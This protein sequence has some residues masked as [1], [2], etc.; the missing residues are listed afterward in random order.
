MKSFL[1]LLVSLLLWIPM[2]SQI[3]G[4]P[5]DTTGRAWNIRFIVDAGLVPL[6]MRARELYN[7]EQLGPGV[8]RWAEWDSTRN[9]IPGSKL[10]HQMISF[11]LG[12]LVNVFKELYVGVNY[13]AY[14]AQ[15]APPSQPAF[16]RTSI[17]FIS[18]SGSVNYSFAFPK[19]PRLRLEPTLSY[20]NYQSDPYAEGGYEGI[21]KEQSFEGRVALAYQYRKKRRHQVRL[22]ASF[23]RMQYSEKTQSL[24]YPDRTRRIFTQWDFLNLGIGITRHI[25]FYEDPSDSP[26]KN[27]KRMKAERKAAKSK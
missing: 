3:F 23:N 11:R 12:I 26:K 10:D 17:P 6:S 19:I 20:G 1:M 9:L 5:N 21:G 18:L 8:W 24:V 2:Q 22:W 7:G 14:I 16:F 15:I 4:R 27:R 25:G 13:S